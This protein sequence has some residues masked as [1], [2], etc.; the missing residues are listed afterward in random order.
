MG[1][2]SLLSSILSMSMFDITPLH[3]ISPIFSLSTFV[4]EPH[5]GDSSTISLSIMMNR[6]WMYL[7][8][9]FSGI[10]YL[11]FWNISNLWLGCLISSTL[12]ACVW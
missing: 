10:L 8:C 5:M 1:F 12:V 11:Q 2:Q 9:I 4:G 6:L 7:P 3:M